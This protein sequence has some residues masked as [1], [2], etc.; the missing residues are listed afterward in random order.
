MVRQIVVSIVLVGV[1]LPVEAAV[2]CA[3]KKGEGTVRIRQVCKAREQ[4]LDPVAL[5]LQGT[6]G[7]KGDKG[8]KGDPGPQGLTSPQGEP[9][10]PPP[11]TPKVLA[12]VSA[13]PGRMTNTGFQ[14]LPG[15]VQGK[16]GDIVWTD[17]VQVGKNDT[18]Q[19]IAVNDKRAF[20]AGNVSNSE[21]SNVDF[22][23]R[24]Y[25]VQRG[26]VLW[27]DRYDSGISDIALAVKTQGKRVFAAG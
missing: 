4:Q 9:G 24:A 15:K 8:E 18:A 19:A 3:P 7:P 11:E 20:V 21:G 6:Q 27:E 17:Q 1:C 13:N 14:D 26:T 23:V 10:V 12:V 16:S 25:D 2:L 5:G 22:F